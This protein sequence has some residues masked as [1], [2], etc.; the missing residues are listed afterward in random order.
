MRLLITLGSKSRE[1]SFIHCSIHCE[2]L[3]TITGTCNSNCLATNLTDRA[4]IRAVISSEQGIVNLL[5]RF[6]LLLAKTKVEF[7]K[8]SNSQTAKTTTAQANFD[9]STKTCK[10]LTEDFKRN[11]GNS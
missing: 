9:A 2:S 10:N 11:L 8:L 3:H 1:D 5:R 6:S 4:P 7:K